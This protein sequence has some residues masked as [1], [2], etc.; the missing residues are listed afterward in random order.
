[1]HVQLHDM[2]IALLTWYTGVTPKPL[3]TSAHTITAVSS[4]EHSCAIFVVTIANT[5]TTIMSPEDYQS[6]RLSILLIDDPDERNLR[7]QM[8][9]SY[10]KKFLLVGWQVQEG[11][12]PA[13]VPVHGNGP[14]IWNAVDSYQQQAKFGR[15]RCGPKM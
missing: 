4:P 1:M 3:W 13:K 11:T 14:W 7:L 9:E 8:L 6:V 2:G 10:Y 5:R 12:Q 15:R